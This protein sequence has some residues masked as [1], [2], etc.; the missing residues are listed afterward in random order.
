MIMS[1]LAR[2][3][4]DAE[5]K[6]TTN[7]MAVCNVALAFTVGFGDRKTTTWVEA[8]IWG[9]QAEGLA[10]HLVK[11]SAI[12]AHLKDIKLEE[13]QKRDGTNGA[14]LTATLVDMEFAGIKQ[15]GAA[16]APQRQAPPP[17]QAPQPQKFED[18][19]DFDDDIPF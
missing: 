2:I 14:K 16:Q 13:Y 12:V 17:R 6:Y 15:E 8:A 11:G 1:G 18:F 10:K 7:G 9:K 3:G 5:L 4:R 19:E